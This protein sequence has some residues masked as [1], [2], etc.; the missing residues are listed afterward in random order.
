[1]GSF[2]DKLAGVQLQAPQEDEHI[3]LWPACE[4]AWHIFWQLHGQW[5]TGVGGKTGF[6]LSCVRT[7]L[8]ELGLQPGPERQEL[9]HMLLAAQD[10]ALQAW[11]KLREQQEAQRAAA[12]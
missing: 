3:Y 2:M 5:H 9:W 7:H 1:M 12:A 10:A 6:S 8:D 11:A 4:Q